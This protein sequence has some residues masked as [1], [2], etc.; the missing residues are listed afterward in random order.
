[1]AN[2][3]IFK[4]LRRPCAQHSPFK[5]E[6]CHPENTLSGS[7]LSALKSLSSG[8]S[9]PQAVRL[10]R[11]QCGQIPASA[12]IASN[13]G[14][15]GAGLGR[16]RRGSSCR[17]AVCPLRL[18]KPLLKGSKLCGFLPGRSARRPGSSS[19]GSY[20]QA[21]TGA[22]QYW[23][24]VPV[25]EAIFGQGRTARSAPLLRRHASLIDGTRCKST[26]R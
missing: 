1:M 12:A 9:I 25:E 2:S 16:G 17:K 21:N 23:P 13:I 10:R 5:P 18:D 14:R 22:A 6:G 19:R 26:F 20:A 3:L 24:G 4:C 8:E 7:P 11:K 15:A